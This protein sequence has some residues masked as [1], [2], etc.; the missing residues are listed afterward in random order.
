M[1]LSFHKSKR[2]SSFKAKRRSQV[3]SWICLPILLFSLWAMEGSSAASFP[4]QITELMYHPVDG[5]EFEFVEIQNTGEAP[6]DLSF[7]SWDGIEFRFAEGD[8][9]QSEEIWIIASNDEPEAFLNRYPD[10]TP[11]GY[12][13]KKL[14]DGG[15]KLTLSDA[16]GHPIAWADYGDS[17]FWPLEA[18][19]IGHSLERV[20]LFDDPNS[21]T[22]WRSS[23]MLNGSPGS[24]STVP[25]SLQ[26]QISEIY[27]TSDLN[28]ADDV[29]FVELWNPSETEIDLSGWR[30]TD[31]GLELDRYILPIG[32]MIEPKSWL[33]VPLTVGTE[34][35]NDS[36][37]FAL[38]AS[39]ETLFLY[40]SLGQPVDGIRF[41]QQ[42][43]GYSIS[44][45]TNR[46]RL[47]LPSPN[48]ENNEAPT[49]NASVLSI[50]EWKADAEAGDTDWIE[51]YNPNPNLPISLADLCLGHGDIMELTPEEVAIT[52]FN[53]GWSV[54]RGTSSPTPNDLTA[55]T[56]REFITDGW[57]QL[58]A[59]FFSGA[60]PGSGT[61]LSDM[62]GN[63]SSL[64]MRREFDIINRDQYQTYRVKAK[65][66]DGFIAW[67]NGSEWGRLHVP[68]GSPSLDLLANNDGPGDFT[69]WSFDFESYALFLDEGP[70]TVAVQGISSNI[71]DDDFYIDFS[72]V[73]VLPPKTAFTIT[74]T[75]PLSSLSFVPPNGFI[76]LNA[77]ENSDI[78]DLQFRLPPEGTTIALINTDD[79]LITTAKVSIASEGVSEGRFPDGADHITYFTDGDSPGSSNLTDK[80]GDEIPDAD[81]LELGLNPED[82]DDA[83]ADRD[84]DGISNIQEYLSGTDLTD[85]KSFF[86]LQLEAILPDGTLRLTAPR[87]SQQDYLIERADDLTNPSWLEHTTIP[88]REDGD[89]G[90]TIIDVTLDQSLSFFRMAGL[91]LPTVKG[92][93]QITVTPMPSQ[94]GHEPEQPLILSLT[95]PIRPETLNQKDAWTLE[96]EFGRRSEIKVRF[97]AGFTQVTLRPQLPL[98]NNTTYQV[99]IHPEITTSSGKSIAA[100]IG[101]WKFSTAPSAPLVDD[102]TP[103]T[104]DTDG[105]IR[106]DVSV[107]DGETP[108]TLED[109]LADRFKDDDFDPYLRVH[110]SGEGFE[111]LL[112]NSNGT[113][114]LRG[115]TSRLTTQ[116]SF[117]IQLDSQENQWRG[118]QRINLMKSPFE[119]TRVRNRLSLELFEQMQHTTSLRSQFVH[120]FINGEDFGL[121]TQVEQYDQRFL[122]NHGLDPNGHLYKAAFFE[123]ARYPDNL[124][125]KSDPSY[126]E[127][128]FEQRLEF[129]TRD[130]HEKLLHLL[131]DI[132][133]HDLDFS[134]LFDQYFN[135]E[136]YLTWLAFNLLT[137]NIDTNSQNFLIYSPSDS[138]TWYFLPWDYDGAWGFNR[139]PSRLDRQ[140]ARWQ[141]GLSNYWNVSLHK[142]FM[143][144]RENRVDLEK[145]MRELSTSVLAQGNIRA[146]LDRFQSLVESFISRPPDLTRLPTEIRTTTEAKVAEWLGEYHRLPSEIP[147]NESL[148]STAVERPMPIFLGNPQQQADSIRFTWSES[149]QLLGRPF[150][151]DFEL[152]SS[153]SFED[154]TI[155]ESRSG[156]NQLNL[157]LAPVPLEGTYFFRV[158]IRSSE[159]PETDWQ[160]PFDTY[161]D[162]VSE[163][164][165][166][167]L[168]AFSVN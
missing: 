6:V 68:G 98:R 136:N 35:G 12:F 22:A 102:Q 7:A 161:F 25:A 11:K 36:A 45:I 153:P 10:L 85:P 1:N 81:E 166:R 63:Y 164:R 69:E 34:L 58:T 142:R 54:F 32:T 151:Y 158:F 84:N 93:F 162:D 17:G 126:D 5:K 159:D 132:N 52:P 168:K 165:F 74:R 143:R 155:L 156:L 43:T 95:E 117:R 72:L 55:W 56:R 39:G 82:P 97:D 88:A 138:Q 37:G 33:A 140:S 79:E 42:V 51:L 18:D 49:A 77:S 107:S 75:S 91:P 94:S 30:I 59:P 144:I 31:S 129:K 86:A 89:L 112:E 62:A 139:Q 146:V 105:V 2:R 20:D 21:P 15:E 116:K 100:E 96:D 123:W 108:F 46:W 122:E 103:Y 44:R 113:M 111:P 26:I 106:I 60:N 148:Y 124:K 13:G 137:S 83:Q 160:L 145:T 120:L 101:E 70:N 167:G 29:D 131:D 19:G 40:D 141:E 9:I 121:F 41:G 71:N 38:G 87:L 80:D 57:E 47:S 50:N 114:K 127:D 147:F 4:I 135:R 53:T 130:D 118:H 67:F 133:N 14:S 152:S 157:E 90:F 3:E 163:V 128:L 73:G 8:I 109:L 66:D 104:K 65:S 48:G 28:K 76:R 92:P 78:D 23:S 119:V 154:G 64:L 24:H 149:E 16:S 99:S 125:V 110:V 134:K 115:A 27:A 61:E 150:T